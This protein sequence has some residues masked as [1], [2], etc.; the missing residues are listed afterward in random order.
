MAKALNIHSI[1]VQI[2]KLDDNQKLSIIERLI[3]ML[4]EKKKKKK[5]VKITDLK[6]LGADVWK[7][8]NIDNYIEN[9]R[10]W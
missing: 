4:K 1:L 6:G 8:I 7:K 10:Q 2:E 9:E 5:T 3:E